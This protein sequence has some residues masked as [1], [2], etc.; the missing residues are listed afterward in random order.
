MRTRWIVEG[1]PSPTH[2]LLTPDMFGNLRPGTF[3]LQHKCI[4]GRLFRISAFGN[5]SQ[6]PSLLFVLSHHPLFLAKVPHC[7]A[8]GE[9]PVLLWVHDLIMARNIKFHGVRGG[10]ASGCCDCA[11]VLESFEQMRNYW[12]LLGKE[13]GFAE[14][15]QGVQAKG[16]AAT[17][18]INRHYCRYF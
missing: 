15:L 16:S 11:K 5:S 17:R 12:H 18:G 9:L 6:C 4:S 13:L 14:H 2:W 7:R 1:T 10:L 3:K 8:Q